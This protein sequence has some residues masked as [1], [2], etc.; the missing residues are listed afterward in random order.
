VIRY[1]TEYFADT[2]L[3]AIRPRHISGYIAHALKEPHP[4]LGRPL[5]AK[6]V[7]LHIS[8]LHDLL[9]TAVAHEL[10]DAN[11]ADGVERPRPVKQQWRILEPTEVRR[12]ISA[13]ADDR[14]RLIFLTLILTGVRRCELVSLRWA[15]ISLTE[16][17][18]R[19]VESKSDEGLRVIQ[20]PPVLVAA[21]ADHYA[22]TPYKSDDDY[23]FAHHERGTRL[24]A[25]WYRVEFQNALDAAGIE[26]RIRPFHDLRHS[27]L[28]NLALT[29]EANE[30]VLMET[31]GH[32]SFATTR[33]YLHLA[34]RVFP[35]AAQALQD[36]LIG[37]T[38][39]PTL[40][41]SRLVSPDPRERET[42]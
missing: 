34:G 41:P 12:V 20:M 31:A 1:L 3:G 38:L 8:V 15:N 32:K 23:V 7:Q 2:P 11:P 24:D 19:V 35:D 18:L 22:A 5:S 27:A 13:F 40:Y 16:G 21:L 17:T 30:L 36:R 4:R 42:A 25:A 6:S 26:G 33:Q 10:I 39:Y 29:P 28:T 37:P 9:Q 14:A